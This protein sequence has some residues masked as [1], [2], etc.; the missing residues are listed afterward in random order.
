MGESVKVAVAATKPVQSEPVRIDK[1]P[2]SGGAK[3][4]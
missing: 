1:I 2:N 4:S 3:S